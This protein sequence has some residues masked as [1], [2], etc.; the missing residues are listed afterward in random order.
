VVEVYQTDGRGDLV[1]KKQY[2]GWRTSW[3]QAIAGQFGKANLL[4]Y[5]ATNDVGEFW[6]M[7]TAGDLQFIEGW[8]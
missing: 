7:D 2:T 8:S 1:L 6:F 3:D 5:D 4:F